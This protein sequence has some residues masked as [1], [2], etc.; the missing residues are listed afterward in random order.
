MQIIVNILGYIG[1]L[2][3]SSGSD[4]LGAPER[5]TGDKLSWLR[6]IQILIN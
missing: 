6:E 4:P 3:I 1:I 5:K 2:D